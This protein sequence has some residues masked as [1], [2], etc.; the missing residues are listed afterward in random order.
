MC[1]L[2]PGPWQAAIV[3][4]TTD[5]KAA[6]DAVDKAADAVGDAKVALASATATTKD[7]LTLELTVSL[8]LSILCPQVCHAVVAQAHHCCHCWVVQRKT[9]DLRVALRALKA[10]NSKLVQAFKF[11]K[12]AEINL[13][14][15]EVKQANLKASASRCRPVRLHP[16]SE[17]KLLPVHGMHLP[18]PLP[19]RNGL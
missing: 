6:S 1:P 8:M 5:K 17:S 4:A 16:A 7:T 19:S 9:Q 15:L 14:K 2:G 13:V 12:K 3:T 11:A 10:A 18:C